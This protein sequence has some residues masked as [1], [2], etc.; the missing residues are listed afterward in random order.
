MSDNN[1]NDAKHIERERAYFM[2]ALMGLGM[3]PEDAAVVSG[4]KCVWIGTPTGATIRPIENES[5]DVEAGCGDGPLLA[6]LRSPGPH[7]R[8]CWALDHALGRR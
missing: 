8:G 5:E 1:P 7:V 4:A 3:D 6:H 2:R